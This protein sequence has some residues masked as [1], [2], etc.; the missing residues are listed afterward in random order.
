METKIKLWAVLVLVVLFSM[1]FVS[2]Q[3]I[4]AQDK[5]TFDEILEPVNKIYSLVK[6]IS[7]AIASM[8]L[9]F[10]G[11]SYVISGS[12]PGKRENSKNMMMYV[13]I[14]LVIIWAAPLVVSF[15]AG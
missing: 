10:A 9:L 7:T 2:A 14:G 3:T 12:D 6:Y 1:Q 8:V 13:M 4:S 15:I 11:A 5:A